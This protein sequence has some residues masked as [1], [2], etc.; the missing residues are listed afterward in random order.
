MLEK[1]LRGAE[2][3]ARTVEES[4]RAAEDRV[5]RASQRLKGDELVR[6]KT[7]K[8]LTIAMKLLEPPG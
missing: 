2:E 7:R 3:R 1:S 8:A 4:L 6:E 5:V